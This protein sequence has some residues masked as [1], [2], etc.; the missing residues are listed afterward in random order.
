MQCWMALFLSSGSSFANKDLLKPNQDSDMDKRSLI[1]VWIL[2]VDRISI[3]FYCNYSSVTQLS[4]VT[5]IFLSYPIIS[6]V[7]KWCFSNVLKKKP[8]L[9][10]IKILRTFKLNISLQSTRCIG[11]FQKSGAHVFH[12]LPNM[13]TVH[14]FVSYMYL[15]NIATYM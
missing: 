4:I 9:W 11:T 12:Y 6:I 15:L 10:N 5:C 2:M 3:K 8:V 13:Q 14:H 7:F 1:H